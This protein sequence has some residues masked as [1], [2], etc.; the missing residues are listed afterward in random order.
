MI[1]I[2]GHRSRILLRHVLELALGAVFMA[3]MLASIYVWHWSPG[4]FI[5][6]AVGIP[7]A[8]HSIGALIG[9]ALRGEW[10]DRPEFSC[11]EEGLSYRT[12][13]QG[14]DVHLL[15]TDYQGYDFT[16]ELPSRLKIRRRNGRPFRIDLYAF[17]RVDRRNLYE[18][19]DMVDEER[20]LGLRL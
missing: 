19:L 10:R 8:A 20:R 6:A 9:T 11:D 7:V 16:W 2:A 3:T 13:K 18:E 1:H 15:W 4:V 14:E 5:G 17:S 12:G